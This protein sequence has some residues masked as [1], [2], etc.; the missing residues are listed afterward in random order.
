MDIL[1]ET[2]R[3]IIRELQPTDVEGMFDLDSNP[4]VHQ[5]LGNHPVQTKDEIAMVIDFIRQQYKDHGI[6]RWA[7]VDKETNEF[8]G[9]TGFKY[10]TEAINKQVNYYDL[11]YRLRKKYWGKGLATEAGIACLN[12]G[13][14]QLGYRE[15]FAMADCANDGSNRI[16]R[17]LG[18][19][20]I[21][22]FDWEGEP[23]F[24]YRL[25]KAAFD[26]KKTQ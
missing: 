18:F 1:I 7:M 19:T 11:G 12:Y 6:G 10:I 17:K 3:L 9:W 21:E 2:A 16:L 4:E 13:F 23:H 24:W 15:V 14:N 8:I 26:A 20:G 5:Y 25:D 22:T